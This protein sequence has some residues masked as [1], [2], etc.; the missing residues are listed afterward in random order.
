MVV[1]KSTDNA[2]CLDVAIVSKIVYF[3][4]SQIYMLANVEHRDSHFQYITHD[5]I[6]YVYELIKCG[7]IY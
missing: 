3:Q 4:H 6:T 5:L 1:P 2:K 7:E